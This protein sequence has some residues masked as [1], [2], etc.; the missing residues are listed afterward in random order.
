MVTSH[1]RVL[2]ID[3]EHM[4]AD[5]MVTI[6]GTNGAEAR[7]AYTAEQAIEII[8]EWSPELAIIELFFP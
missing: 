3:D 8:S 6:L 2:C 4:I 7:A 1:R 5:T